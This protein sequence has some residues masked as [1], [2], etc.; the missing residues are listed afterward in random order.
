MTLTATGGQCNIKRAIMS[1][2]TRRIRRPTARTIGMVA[3]LTKE[4]QVQ[5]YNT[6]II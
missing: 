2:F 6:T 3:T 1:T 5:N 4:C